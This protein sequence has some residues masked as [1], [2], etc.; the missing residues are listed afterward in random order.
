M[1]IIATLLLLLF[2]TLNVSASELQIVVSSDSDGHT[3]SARIFSKYLSNYL[4]NKP[5]II[6]RVV[7]GAAGVN[8]TN[9]LYNIAPR[10]GKTIGIMFKN[11]P[12]IGA[13]G[14]PNI[15]F[16]ASKF[17]WIGSFADGRLDASI[18][19]SNKELPTDRELIVGS[20]NVVLA[21]PVDFIERYA[22][23]NIRKIVGYN[24][25]NAIRLAFLRNEVDAFVTS[26]LG[27]TTFDPTWL[28]KYPVLIQ[29]G[30][31]KIKHPQLAKVPT[32][33]EMIKDPD[34]QKILSIIEDQFALIRPYVAPPEIPRAAAEKLR[35]AFKKS[36][37]DQQ[38]AEEIGKLH[39]IVNPIFHEE[40][41]AIVNRTVNIDPSLREKLK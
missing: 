22:G 11:I 8:S 7:P 24:S 30:N 17:T 21:N 19:I 40:A 10:D 5:R 34:G 32:L 6:F 28:N 14:G 25:S 3:T 23:L 41:Q 20:D 26:I 2:G 33:A 27:V 36:V 29:F 13:I 31:G 1:K 18:L 35:E 4:P 37:E 39:I 12:I 16:D 38:F 15:N 9:Y